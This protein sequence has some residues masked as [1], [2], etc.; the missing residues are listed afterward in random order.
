MKVTK[1]SAFR[2]AFVS[3]RALTISKPSGSAVSFAPIELIT[4]LSV[5]VRS[6]PIRPDL[7]PI[8]IYVK[9]S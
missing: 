5:P 6:D 2:S 8:E 3:S 4:T 9:V 1:L 7:L